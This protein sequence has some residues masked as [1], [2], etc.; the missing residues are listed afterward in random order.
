MAGEESASVMEESKVE[1]MDTSDTQWNWFYLGECGKWHIFEIGNGKNGKLFSVLEMKQTNTNT[2]KQRAVKRAPFCINAFSFICGNEQIPIPPH[3]ENIDKDI[4]YQLSTL[5]K[6]SNEH[7]E[8]AKLFGQTMDQSRIKQVHRIQN[9][10][11]WEFYCR[12]KIHLKKIRHAI[13]L[14]ERMLFHG[15]S[16][17]FV[18]AI[19]LQNFDWRINGVHATVYGKGTYFA[20]DAFYSSRYCRL[21]E[22]HGSAFQSLGVMLSPSA[23]FLCKPPLKSMFL[24]RVLVGDYV[25][26]DHNY[27]RPPSKDGTFVNLYDS[28]VDNTWNPKIFVIFD[29]NQIYPEY[30]I[31]FS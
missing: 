11:L 22:K 7:Q 12:K 29:A 2:G 18:E 16:S 15:T 14:N 4:P 19:C 31:E 5:L 9:L 27:I 8:V 13:D 20:R 28:C 1:D 17:E 3:W 21:D 24:A 26:G 6:S 30:L 10:D 23:P 25:T